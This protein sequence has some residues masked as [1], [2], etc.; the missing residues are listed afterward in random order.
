MS[1]THEAD[2]ED[3]VKKV[4]KNKISEYNVTVQSTSSE[5]H[6]GEPER[7]H[8][9]RFVKRTRRRHR[10]LA[11]DYC[12]WLD[13]STW[14]P[15]ISNKSADTERHLKDKVK[16]FEEGLPWYRFPKSHLLTGPVRVDSTGLRS[17]FSLWV[18]EEPIVSSIL[19]RIPLD[20]TLDAT[21]YRSKR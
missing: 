12:S 10:H 5:S 3:F 11:Q 7:L 6:F 16:S 4:D 1:S 14:A 8:G 15:T 13:E 9:G 18:G 17:E 19:D 21:R 20:E 2:W